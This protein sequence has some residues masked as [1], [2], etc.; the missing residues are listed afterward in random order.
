MECRFIV[1][2]QRFTATTQGVEEAL[3][4]VRPERVQ[5]HGVR[6]GGTVYPVNQAFA[7]AFGLVRADFVSQTARRVFRKLGFAV[8][9]PEPGPTGE[10]AGL[11]RKRQVGIGPEE[12]EVLDIPGIYLGWSRWELWED[13][14]KTLP[15]GLGIELPRGRPGV[16]EARLEGDEERLVIGKASD[17]SK[18]IKEG[19]IRGNLAHTAGRKIRAQEHTN[20]VEVRWAITQ[21]PAAAEEVLHKRHIET[22]GRLPKYTGHT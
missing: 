5:A 22:F 7:I 14:A 17:L 13:L 16:Y 18:R 20:L 11:R 6:I 15:R 4:H 3:H 9:G 19:L 12:E 1:N 2:G 8:T 21:W 10:A